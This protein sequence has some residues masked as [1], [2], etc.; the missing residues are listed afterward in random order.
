MADID[1]AS[2]VAGGTADDQQKQGTH[3][4]HTAKLTAQFATLIAEGAATPQR[5]QELCFTLL[6]SFEA[7]RVDQERQI[8][9]YQA[10][11]AYCRAQQQSC[12]QFSNL[13]VGIL[14]RQVQE[15]A[16]A[17]QMGDP[18][19]AP[20][21]SPSGHVVTDTEMLQRICICGCV[22]EADAANCDCECH[23]ER[24][25]CID[26]RCAVCPAK[27]ALETSGRRQAPQP[28]KKPGKARKKAA[29]KKAMP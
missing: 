8:S 21:A 10:K 16:R 22:D 15:V 17:R 2:A 27:R 7:M 23:S 5:Y 12:S 9:D 6:K 14:A 24:G 4:Q 3:P 11:I 25:Y 13:L 28:R 19:P 1:V 20:Q 29:K 26:A 18:E